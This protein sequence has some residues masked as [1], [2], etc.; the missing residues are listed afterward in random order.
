VTALYHRRRFVFV[1]VLRDGSKLLRFGLNQDEDFA[2]C[3]AKW[4]GP[5]ADESAMAMEGAVAILHNAPYR[6]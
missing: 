3:P 4:R 1:K 6:T 5:E 2:A